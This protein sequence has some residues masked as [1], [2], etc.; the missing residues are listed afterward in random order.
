MPPSAEQLRISRY[1]ASDREAVFL[2]T[3]TR[4]ISL[5]EHEGFRKV[6]PS[7]ALWLLGSME[8]RS[9]FEVRAFVS[10][11]RLSPLPLSRVDDQQLLDLVRG[12]VRT[13]RLA[14][15]RPDG[16]ASQQASDETAQQR[17]LIRKIEQSVRGRLGLAGR[18]YK[19]VADADLGKLPGRDDYEVVRHDEAQS[20]LARLAAQHAA[21][22]LPDLLRQASEKL[23]RD[24]RPPLSQPDGIIL[25]RRL[26][27]IAAI[28]REAG[29]AMT[30]SQLAKL[31]ADEK[32][33][34]LE[35]VVL[36]LDDKPVKGLT[37]VIEA[38]DAETHEGDL[39]G[40]AK[41]KITSTKKGTASVT[42]KW[43]EAGAKA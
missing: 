30:P 5:C 36:G 12:H 14:G 29:P 24:W 7:H 26:P 25:L 21:G 15:V 31:L 40:G 41:T 43:A 38:P 3:C 11:M 16:A 39:G 1:L 28:G 27:V 4:A 9:Y 34:T 6:A 17:R 35:V 33:V 2:V 37:Y 23:T 42:L 22:E 32:S 8:R 20:A 13:G 10:R 18:A 19:L